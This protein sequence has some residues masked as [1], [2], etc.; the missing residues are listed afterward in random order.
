MFKEQQYNYCRNCDVS[1]CRDDD[2]SV[3]KMTAAQEALE[4]KQ[5]VMV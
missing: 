1:S 4:E 5:K 3:A 2:D